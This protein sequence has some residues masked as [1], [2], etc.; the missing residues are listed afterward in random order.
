MTIMLAEAYAWR[1]A[2][3]EMAPVTVAAVVMVVASRRGG[4]V[5]DQLCAPRATP[6]MLIR[7]T[8]DRSATEQPGR[9][10]SS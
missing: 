7:V 2:A 3:M 5:P 10:T 6:I 8:V 1:V 9:A 4:I